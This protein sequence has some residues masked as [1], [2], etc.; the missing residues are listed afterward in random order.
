M[1]QKPIKKTILIAPLDWGLGH[2]ARCVPIVSALQSYR[3]QV[4]IA[5]DSAVKTMLKQEFPDVQF[6]HLPGYKITYSKNKKWFHFNLLLQFPRII[7]RII[8]EHFWLKK[9][10]KRYAIDAV[11]SDNRFGLYH[12]AIPSVYITH[13]LRIKTGN[14]Y[15]ENIAAKIHG[16]F[17]KKYSQC[18]VP[19]F[20][21]AVNI[22]GALSH[23]ATLPQ[24]VKYIGCLSRFKKA[25]TTQ[26]DIDLL[27]ILSGPEPQRTIFE[28]MLL[29]QLPGYEG[30]VF[31]VRGLPGEEGPALQHLEA[32][33]KKV[34]FYNHLTARALN[35]AMDAAHLVLSR[36][37]YTTIMDLLKIQ[38]K[39][40]LVPT[41][42]QA[43]QEYLAS[44]LSQQQIFCTASQEGFL[45]KDVIG[46]A[47]NFAFKFPDNDMDLYK[48]IIHQFVET[49]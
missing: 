43:E 29:Q 23:P 47:N 9:V 16:W 31:F 42:G 48:T 3:I 32:S 17:I 24:H 37:G 38:Q 21:G 8:Q 22:A 26:K 34:V 39:A 20:A 2:A 15:S 33:N 6:I 36:S 40:V 49:L 19:D 4:M 28:N 13:Q 7:T 18:W 1:D 10:V 46:R 14:F 12:A 45:L 25:V 41:P 5:A 30:N 44:F 27:I 35:K 11:I